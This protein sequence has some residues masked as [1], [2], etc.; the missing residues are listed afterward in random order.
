M[1]KLGQRWQCLQRTFYCLHFL[2]L[3]T[4]RC[5]LKQLSSSQK[6]PEK[7]AKAGHYSLKKLIQSAWCGHLV[8]PPLVHYIDA[9]PIL[10][11]SETIFSKKL[12]K[13]RNFSPQKLNE[14]QKTWLVALKYFPFNT[15]Y[16]SIALE[17]YGHI[18]HCYLLFLHEKWISLLK[19]A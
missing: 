14:S 12:R 11:V 17:I 13:L 15:S 5:S 9:L 10:T 19:W 7:W 18:L 8:W 4:F 2:T 16:L 1:R 3:V 6:V